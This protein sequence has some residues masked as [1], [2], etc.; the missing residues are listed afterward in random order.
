MSTANKRASFDLSP[1]ISAGLDRRGAA[2]LTRFN[3]VSVPLRPGK[4]PWPD[5]TPGVELERNHYKNRQSK[6]LEY[7]PLE[8]RILPSVID[9]VRKASEMLCA[10]SRRPSGPRGGGDKADI[11]TEIEEFLAGELRAILPACFVGEET[12]P[13]P[14][15]DSPYCWLVDPHDGTSAYLEGCRG[16]AVSVALLRDGVPVLGVVCAPMG[17]DRGWDLIAWAEGLSHLL[18]NGEKVRVDL[19]SAELEAGQVVLLNHRTAT[20]PVTSGMSIAPARFVSLPSIAYRL[21][22]VAVGDGVVAVS[23]NAPCGLDYAAGHAL[24][25][26]ARGVLLDEAGREVTYDPNGAS[27]VQCCFGGAPN[28]VRALV[29]RSWSSPRREAL[30]SRTV[31]VSWPRIATDDKADRAVGCLFG[32]LIGDN[33][34]ALVEFEDEEQVAR[35]Y[36]G[37]PRDLV[38]GGTWNILAGQATDD[39]ELALTLARSLLKTGTY[40][41]EAVATAYGDWLA[42][43]PFDIGN[44]T[45]Q[46]LSAANRAESNH[47]AHAALT[48]ANTVSQGNGSLMRISPIG[49]WGNVPAVANSFAREDSRLTHPNEICVDACGV[50]AT[51][52]ALGIQ[53]RGDRHLML[54]LPRAIAKTNEVRDALGRAEEGKIPDDYYKNMGW[55]LIALQNA[56]YHLIHTETF[57]EALVATVRKG[58]DTDTNG[59]IAGA[60]LG[61]ACGSSRIPSRWTT[62]VMACRPH[63][64]LGANSPRP[65]DYWPDDLATIAEALLTAKSR[66]AD[67]FGGILT[68]ALGRIL[69][70]EPADHL[71]GYVWTLARGRANPG[72]S[73]ETAAVREVREK[74]GYHAR[75]TGLLPGVF[76]GDTSTTLFFMMDTSPESQGTFGPETLRTRWVSPE[77]AVE[78]VSMNETTVGRHRDLDVIAAVQDFFRGPE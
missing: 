72:E 9:S 63:V 16:T 65:M 69:L 19:S 20:A 22:R 64:S 5:E 76:R 24:L 14:G 56:F 38:D 42:S 78:L 43:G 71:G 77:K 51:A 49:I 37:G 75:I 55:V 61:A 53:T 32:Q 60:L 13:R 17:P 31:S 74:S 7:M 50:F 35:R 3:P 4:Q 48:R 33:L 39:S 34:G 54:R 25:R 47:K 23:R 10:E 15:D 67:A 62:P 68:D 12:R 66:A 40:D 44:T 29:T 8:T 57:E 73:A 21:A 36:P 30:P 70:R 2:A 46:A 6:G 18:R 59:A 58:G 26:G 1:A 27:Q 45:R 28:A 52:I 41:R 11:D